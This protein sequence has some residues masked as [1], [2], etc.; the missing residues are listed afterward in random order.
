MAASPETLLLVVELLVGFDP[1]S[2]KALLD[3]CSLAFLSGECVEAEPQT[4]VG[5]F[6]AR[7]EATGSEHHLVDVTLS[8][9]GQQLYASRELSFKPEDEESERARSLGLSVGVLA[10]SLEEER[11]AQGIPTRTQDVAA[12]TPAPPQNEALPPESA[13]LQPEQAQAASKKEDGA[14]DST[15]FLLGLEAGIQFDPGWNGLAAG[16]GAFAGVGISPQL[17]VLGRFFVAHQPQ[18]DAHVGLTFL[19]PSGGLA[20]LFPGQRLRPMINLEVGAEQVTTSIE[21]TGNTGAVPRLAR[22]AGFARAGASLHAHLRGGLYASLSPALLFSFSPT[23]IT[24]D[25][26]DQGQTGLVRVIAQGGLTWIH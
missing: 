26:V 22:W 7:I 16:G 8:D 13:A 21:D 5:V 23:V 19:A 1:A 6:S 17:F 11:N 20:W 14:R 3:A 15:L 12:D 10:N 4:R 25:G 24:V 2:K 18:S 9:Q